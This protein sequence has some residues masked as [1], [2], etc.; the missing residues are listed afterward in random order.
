MDIEREVKEA[1][2]QA[3]RENPLPEQHWKDLAE[4]I[5]KENEDYKVIAKH[6]RVQGEKLSRC[7]SL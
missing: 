4:L 6:Q 3:M 5:R 2:L 7:F 1:F